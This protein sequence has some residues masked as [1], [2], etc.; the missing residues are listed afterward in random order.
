MDFHGGFGWHDISVEGPYFN[1]LGYEVLA[2][3]IP[4]HGLSWQFSKSTTYDQIV[5]SLIEFL[6][7]TT[8]GKKVFLAGQSFGGGLALEMARREPK[9][10]KKLIIDS[11]II[12]P[13]TA[14]PVR[15]IGRYLYEGVIS[16]TKKALA[17]ERVHI[18]K[19]RHPIRRPKLKNGRT[20]WHL[21]TTLCVDNL[22]KI[23]V[24]TMVIYGKHDRVVH[25]E[26]IEDKIKE[27]PDCR[28][29]EINGNHGWSLPK[30]ETRYQLIYNFAQ[31]ES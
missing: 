11:P 18:Q 5:E 23:T 4:G 15:F 17:G 31:A 26:S 16:N 2:P 30:T 29:V 22:G 21:L 6:K 19:E 8:K 3:S 20:L 1:R 27:I 13:V 25:F 14:N 24:P 12:N 7:K 28:L 10:I 9:L